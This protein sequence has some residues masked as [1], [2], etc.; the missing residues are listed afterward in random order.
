MAAAHCSRLDPSYGASCHQALAHLGARPH[1][2][3]SRLQ[4]MNK[5]LE[6]IIEPGGG[7][8]EAHEEA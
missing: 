6:T 2:R 1:G 7:T 8:R 4:G 3:F 5:V